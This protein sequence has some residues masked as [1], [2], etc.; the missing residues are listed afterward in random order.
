MIIHDNVTPDLEGSV[1]AIGVFDGIHLGHQAVIKEAVR[2]SN[3]YQVPSVVYTFDPPPR[4][5][6]QQ[7]IILTNME[8]KLNILR[9]LHVHQVIVAKF[10]ADYVQRS[11]ESF[12]R[13]LGFLNPKEILVGQD[14][15]FGKEREGNVQNLK[16]YFNVKALEPVRCKKGKI[17][18]STRIR[19]LITQGENREAGSLLG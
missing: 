7:S 3:Y 5:Y 9:G 1:V 4:A 14:F 2:R 19:K 10:D 16:S 6:F 8:K 11:A 15:R 12:V 13:E 17:I 18:S